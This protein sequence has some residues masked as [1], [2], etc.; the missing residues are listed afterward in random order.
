MFYDIW[1]VNMNKLIISYQNIF[2]LYIPVNQPLAVQI[3]DPL[4]DI[5]CHLQATS[6]THSAFYASIQI[7]LH[8]FHDQ[9]N[10]RRTAASVRVVDD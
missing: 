5:H 6:K 9:E 2:Q 10:R 3:S 8:S 4:Y 1:N 7:T